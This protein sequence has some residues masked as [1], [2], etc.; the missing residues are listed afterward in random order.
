MKRKRFGGAAL[1]LLLGLAVPGCAPDGGG[2]GGARGEPPPDE[3]GAVER[4]LLPPGV[5]VGGAAAGEPLEMM[6]FDEVWEPAAPPRVTLH[7]LVA[8]LEDRDRLRQTVMD[9]LEA[10]SREEPELAAIR[11]VG[12]MGEPGSGRE[13]GLIPVVWGEWLPPD[14]WRRVEARAADGLYRIYIYHGPP[15][16]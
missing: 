8:A 15:E 11:V 2:W 6:L 4:G 3:R 12:Y 7:V 1:L 9:L 13:V 10:R 5:V 16:W 14:G